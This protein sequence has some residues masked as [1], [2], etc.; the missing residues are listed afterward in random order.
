MQVGAQMKLKKTM[1]NKTKRRR[2]RRSMR[3]NTRTRH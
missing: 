1:Q 2:R 3:R